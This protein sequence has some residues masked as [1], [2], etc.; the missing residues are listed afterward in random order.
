MSLAE[1]RPW[2]DWIP[3][4]LSKKQMTALVREE[5][6]KGASLDAIDYSSIDLHLSEEAYE[7]T[8]GSVKPFGEDRYLHKVK[9]AGLVESLK[10]EANGTFVLDPMRTYLFKTQESLYAGALKESPIHGQA[11]AKSSVGRVDVLARL[12]VD[13]MDSYEGFTPE[14]AGTGTGEMFLEITPIT[15][16]IIVKPGIAV[17]Q[18]R[19]FCGRPEDVEVRGT[20]AY[21]ALLKDTT[22]EDGTLSVDLSPVSCGGAKAAAF[23]ADGKKDHKPVPLWRS[24]T[25]PD[26]C[27]YWKLEEAD[28]HQRLQIEG[29]RFYILR[30]KEKIAVP[31]G[32]AVYCKAIDE[33]IGEIR[34]HYAGFVHPFFGRDRS[35]DKTGTPLI[36]EV[37]GHAIDVNLRD[38]EKLAKLTFYRMSEDAEK[39]KGGEEKAPDPYNDQQLQLSKFFG[40]WPETVEVDPKTRSVAPKRA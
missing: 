7:L 31:K 25:P 24:D 26:P 3:G 32:I 21:H 6:I 18:L 39:D 37:R 29:D 34:I 19:F 36:F 9:S 1:K 13:G 23:R 30:S 20:A 12:I 33:T 11:T 28:E 40:K 16:Q 5:Y 10:R 38:G 15:F 17:S 4:V 8:H 2:D 14:G 27:D 35:D 22:S